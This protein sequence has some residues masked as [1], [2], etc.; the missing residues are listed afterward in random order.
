MKILKIIIFI[1]VLTAIAAILG[2]FLFIKTLDLNHFKTQI[3]EQIG[4]SIGREVSIKNILFNFSL[5][6]GVIFDISGLSIID[7]PSFS[8]ET[9]IYIDSA[10]FDIDILPFFLDRQVRIV[11]IELNSPKVNFIRNNKGKVNFEGLKP[12][13]NALSESKVNS[14]KLSVSKHP[15]QKSSKKE[16]KQ[17]SFGKMSVHSLRVTDGTFIYTDQSSTPEVVVPVTNIDLKVSNI[18]LNYLN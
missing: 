3:Q 2:L 14:K 7:Q 10:H 16:E 1:L 13:Q 5:R 15:P 12:R 9:M 18:S 4:N 8:S 6:R 11:K 17:I